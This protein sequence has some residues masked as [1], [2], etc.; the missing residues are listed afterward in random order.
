MVRQ[1]EGLGGASWAVESSPG[2]DLSKESPKWPLQILTCNYKAKTKSTLCYNMVR[3]RSRGDED[4][5]SALPLQRERNTWASS[6]H[7]ILGRGDDVVLD[8]EKKD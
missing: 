7:R 6:A 5:A 4:A 8:K 2:T 1:N 3:G